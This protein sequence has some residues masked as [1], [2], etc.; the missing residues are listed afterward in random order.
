MGLIKNELSNLK[1]TDL[2]SFILFALYKCKDLPEYSGL[3]ELAYILDKKNFLKLCEY[4]GGLTLHIP[5]VTELETF[6]NA[7]LLY[8]DVDIEHQSLEKASANLHDDLDLREIKAAYLS[9]KKVM[10]EYSFY[11]KGS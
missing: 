4:F 11:S 9:I 2:W 6:L 7:L 3:S 8:K 1:E 10:A 5:T